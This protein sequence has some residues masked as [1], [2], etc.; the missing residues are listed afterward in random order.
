[1]SQNK[2]LYSRLCKEWDKILSHLTHYDFSGIGK[3]LIDTI[4]LDDD[5][6]ACHYIKDGKGV[7]V[8][9]PRV[10]EHKGCFTSSYTPH[11]IQEQDILTALLLHEIGHH[12]VES[13][14]I[15]KGKD[16]EVTCDNFAQSILKRMQ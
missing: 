8:V 1:M 4:Q 10:F 14:Q 15:S 9:D 3:V 6:Y 16:E 5:T 12:L 2:H 13:D 11:I 7:I